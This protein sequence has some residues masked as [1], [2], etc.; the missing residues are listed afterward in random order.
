[1][2]LCS[3]VILGFSPT[4]SSSATSNQFP[5]LIKSTILTAV[6]WAFFTPPALPFGE[7]HHFL[8]WPVQLFPKWFLWS[9]SPTSSHLSWPK[10]M[11]IRIW[12][13]VKDTEYSSISSACV[14]DCVWEVSPLPTLPGSGTS[15]P[16]FTS[17]PWL[18]HE[19]TNSGSVPSRFERW[20]KW[21]YM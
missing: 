10:Q 11:L 18:C 16:Y 5:K 14:W 15:A 3:G 21:V 2:C 6:S 17:E 1:M 8:P 13:F 20:G 4:S 12:E 19:K 7:C 9:P